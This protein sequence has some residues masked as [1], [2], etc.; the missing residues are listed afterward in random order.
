MKVLLL[1]EQVEFALFVLK[2]TLGLNNKIGRKKK[3][4]GWRS[5]TTWL[6]FPNT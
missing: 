3:G 1:M 4:F 2:I 5:E 6:I